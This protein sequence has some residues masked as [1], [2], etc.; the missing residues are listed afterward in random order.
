MY[1]YSFQIVF[2]EVPGEISLCFSISGCTIRCKGCHSPYLW[3]KNS[4]SLLTVS[5]FE[6]LLKQYANLATCVLFM[7]GEWHNEEL[8]VFLKLS[9]KRNYK[10]CLYTGEDQVSIELLA[11]LT[12]I[13]TGKWNPSLGGLEN[14]KTN[15][16]FIEVK[17]NKILNYLFIKN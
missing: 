14:K 13:K 3:K 10:T 7:G 5:L 11:E 1:Y 8:I 9:K 15:Q 12:W 2:Q 4:G 6:T 16:K 17:T